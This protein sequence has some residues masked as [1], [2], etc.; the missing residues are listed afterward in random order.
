MIIRASKNLGKMDI[1][2]AAP[3]EIQAA[4]TDEGGKA[5]PRKFEMVAYTGGALQL[6]WWGDPVV[7]DLDGIQGLK[8]SRPILHAHDSSQRVGHTQS[9]AVEGGKLIAR[10]VMSSATDIAKEICAQADEGFPWQASIG[11]RVITKEAV[12]AGQSVQCNGKTFHGPISIARKTN[13]GEISFV[14]LGADDNTSAR[15][16]ASQAAEGIKM[17]FE[18][19]LE[20]K[21]F[22]LDTVSDTQKDALR[23]S[24]NVEHPAKE[25]KKKEESKPNA[26]D[27]IK[28]AREAYAK[29][30]ERVAKI[31][32]ICAAH[33][34]MEVET[35][36]VKSEVDIE[37][38][39]IR[40]GWTIEK[41]ELSALRASR[42][43]AGGSAF[44]INTGAG[45]QP[46]AEII[47]AAAC[48]SVGMKEDIAFKGLDDKG[49]TI[50]ASRPLKGISLHA[51]IGM[52]AAS[53]GM[54]IQ[55]GRITEE[56]V[57]QLF[58]L[59]LM[60]HM[61]IKASGGGMGG[62]S[63]MS[64]SGITEN[65]LNKA[66]LAAYGGVASTVSEVGF[67]TDTN[68]FKPFK[69]YRLS[70]SGQMQPVGIGGELKAMTLQDES[71]SNQLGTVG[72]T[73][74]IPR[75]IIMND[76]MGALAD[77]PTLIGR[78]AA[79]ARERAFYTALLS[80]PS[81]FFGTGHL[82][83]LS[84][85]GSALS[86]TSLTS[87]VQLFLQMKDVNGDPILL[88]PD[89]LVVPPALYATAQNLFNGQNLIASS[90]GAT[91]ARV[92]EP[93][94]N[95]HAGKYRPVVSPFLGVTGGLTGGSDT[96]WYLLGSVAGGFSPVQIGYLRGQRTPVVERG[97]ANFNTLGMAMRCYFDF[98][99]A[100][101]DYRTGV[102]SAGV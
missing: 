16:A 83:Y 30:S 102:Y 70:A 4:A 54:H 68:D 87:A 18:K 69:R 52:C 99:V 48:L 89:R 92:V 88:M 15:I 53:R 58:N 60:E 98:G 59:E 31:H 14:A 100:L 36:G 74:N 75:N 44:Y 45:A 27:D 19:W 42:P 39:A 93:N 32:A 51:I 57:K 73:L 71:Y 38:T 5:K 3:V 82:N 77:L 6:A 64:V 9:V 79:L 76:D 35:N 37:A 11:A 84:G 43:N 49:K 91:N 13:L 34:K 20:A 10:G 50:A 46:T 23:A 7:I 61:D 86:I 21:G 80:N 41:T 81:N 26:D 63:T 29:E 72:C 101:H 97:E 22:A 55:A 25:E 94:I 67:E 8:A 33:P 56:S 12:P 47:A 2:M 62:W 65:V 96:G 78:Q 85:A 17:T 95:Q 90:L 24:Y 1:S 28:A 66:M 40:E